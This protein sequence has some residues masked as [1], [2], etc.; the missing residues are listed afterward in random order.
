MT[1]TNQPETEASQPVESNDGAAATSANSLMPL[2]IWPPVLLLVGMLVTRLIPQFLDT[3]SRLPIMLLVF[4][5]LVFGGLIILWWLFASRASLKEKWIGTIVVIA[6]GAA[7]YVSLDP[8]MIGPGIMLITAPMGLGLFGIFA[9]LCS[10]W[11]S[12]KRTCI[13]VLCS[14]LGFGFSTLLRSNGMWGDYNLD[15][16]WRW[17]P[18]AE[19]RMLASDSGQPKNDIQK[20]SN[21]ELD[22]SLIAPE[23]PA[24]RGDR[25][26]GSVSGVT[27]ATDWGDD[28][29]TPLWKIPVGPGW[30]SFVVAGNLLF[31][32]EQRGESE[33]IVCYDTNSGGEVWMQQISSRFYDPLGGPGPRATPTLANGQLFVMGANGHVMRLDPKT[34]EIIWREDIRKVADREP[35]GWGF[36]SSPLIVDSLVIVHAG[37]NN[38]KGLLAFDVE[39]GDLKW[40]TA[41]GDHTY[42][43]PALMTIAGQKV[44]AMLT[45]KEFN[46][47]DPADGTV[48]LN[49]KCKVQGYRALQ[50]QLLEDDS[51]LI[52]TGVGEGIQKIHVTNTDGEWAAEQV[53]NSPKLKPDFNDYVIYQGHAYGF[54]STI[55]VC[56]DLKDGKRKWKGG[57]YGKGQVLLLKDSGQ[58]IVISEQ[59][60]VVLLKANPDAH[61]ELAKFRAI[62]G[63]TW[64]HPVLIGDRLY[65]RN[66]AEA[67]AFRLPLAK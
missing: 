1:A 32:Q 31:T 21:S 41:A 4:G 6:A 7:T 67:A 23:W 45:N 30:S 33:A 59:G 11:L 44:I 62:E 25:R 61:T 14:I 17:I 2:R 38:D 27:L 5:P 50:P 18:S 29:K 49:Y 54:D 43:S 63:K 20:L 34:G 53:W 66:S 64:N 8:T 19:D 24:F 60:D 28:V 35:P 65:V 39:T 57:R 52:A 37:G 56:F 42:S 51:I 16:V 9:I 55:F 12:Y 10:R 36:S 58:L 40:S 22:Q 26:D 48:L 3:E 15:L 47:L 46:L 13:I